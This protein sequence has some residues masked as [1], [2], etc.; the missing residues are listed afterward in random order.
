M[1]IRE[2]ADHFQFCNEFYFSRFFKQHLAISPREYRKLNRFSPEKNISA[3]P[4]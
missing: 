3:D 4:E 2:I 1:T